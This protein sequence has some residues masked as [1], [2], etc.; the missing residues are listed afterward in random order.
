MGTYKSNIAEVKLLEAAP[1]GL[2]TMDELAKIFSIQNR[3]TLY[4]KIGRM[5]K[6]G[7]LERLTKGKYLSPTHKSS[8]FLIANFLYQP[9]YISLESALSFYGIITG[10]SY[11]ISS[12]TVRKTHAI[13]TNTKEYHY[14]QIAPSLFWGYEKQEEFLIADREKSLLD[15]LYMAYKGL[16]KIDISELEF[17]SVSKKKLSAY[18]H[19]TGNRPFVIFAKKYV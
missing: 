1:F 2:F 17:S 7:L 3:N 8:D 13:V 16:K 11:Q 9:S 19:K 5:E 12:I 4:K 10:F 18:L 6:S 15:Y 14:T